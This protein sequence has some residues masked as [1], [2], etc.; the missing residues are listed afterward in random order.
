MAGLLPPLLPGLWDTCR[1]AI[2][3]VTAAT[4]TQ[5]WFGLFV[6]PNSVGANQCD[7]LDPKGT[8]ECSAP[9]DPVVPIGASKAAAIKQALTPIA[10]C[11]ATPTAKTLAAAKTY[12]QALPPDGHAKYVVLATDGGPN[13][14]G[15]LDLKTCSCPGGGC[16][17]PESCVDD[18]ATYTALDDLCAA[19]IKTFIVGLNPDPTLQGVLQ[20]MAQHGCTKTPYA[21]TDAPAIKKAF[22]DISNV[23]S[24]CSF[25]MDCAKVPEPNMVNFYFDGKVVPRNMNHQAGW[26]WSAACTGKTGAGKVEFSGPEC[27]AIK[28]GK[29]KTVSAKFGCPTV[30]IS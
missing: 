19:G 17:I 28:G 6:F 3:N 14:N 26:D 11:G 4:D 30:G 18:K 21:P 13:C 16:T 2:T 22:T 5:V 10:P 1:D 20:Q 8:N 12:L 7:P 24:T 23:V 27:D 25:D 29:V 9:K 15:T